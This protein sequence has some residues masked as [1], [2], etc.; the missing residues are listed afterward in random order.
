M[1]SSQREKRDVIRDRLN[2][3]FIVGIFSRPSASTFLFSSGLRIFQLKLQDVRD[4][5]THFALQVA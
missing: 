5:L 4:I 1:M 2:G 3:G